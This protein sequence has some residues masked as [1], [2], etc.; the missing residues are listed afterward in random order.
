MGE[1]S[2]WVHN[3]CAEKRARVNEKFGRT[4]DL[5]ADIKARGGYTPSTPRIRDSRLKFSKTPDQFSKTL[6][7]E[8]IKDTISKKHGTRQVVREPNSRTRIR[9]ESHINGGEAL[10]LRGAGQN[11]PIGPK[12]TSTPPRLPRRQN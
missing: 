1:L 8:P 11:P 9:F 6:G 10:Q 12:G 4:G 5:H 7:V 2:A 3:M